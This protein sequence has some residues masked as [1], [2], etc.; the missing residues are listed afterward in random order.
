MTGIAPAS[1]TILLAIDHKL[2]RIHLGNEPGLDIFIK[3]PEM[4]VERYHLSW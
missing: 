1:I 3:H 2:S 4:F